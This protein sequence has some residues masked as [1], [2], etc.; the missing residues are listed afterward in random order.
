MMY[1]STLKRSYSFFQALHFI[2]HHLLMTVL[3]IV[4]GLGIV[5]ALNFLVGEHVFSRLQE[6]SLAPAGPASA[7]MFFDN[8]LYVH[9]Y[10]ARKQYI[11][12]CLATLRDEIGAERVYAFT[13]TFRDRRP[14]RE[15]ISNVFEVVREGVTPKHQQLQGLSIAGDQLSEEVGYN[16]YEVLPYIY[17]RELYDSNGRS[18]GY[19]G[20]DRLES[21]FLLQDEQ[22]ELIRQTMRDIEAVLSQPVV[23]LQEYGLD[24]ERFKIGIGINRPVHN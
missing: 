17:G 5:S 1:L 18:I 20:F 7:L 10:P 11:A 14:G 8:P 12:N 13:Y 3:C 22:L 21:F 2:K 16:T 4:A 9:E 24:R 15:K 19:F 6:P 23:R